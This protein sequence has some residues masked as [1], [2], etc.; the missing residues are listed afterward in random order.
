M[1]E[2]IATN[3]FKRLAEE[4][5]L[6]QRDIRVAKQILDSI[7]QILTEPQSINRWIFELLQNAADSCCSGRKL[8]ISID[9]TKE[10]LKFSHN[11]KAFVLEDL[12]NLIEQ[13]SSKERISPP[14]NA[15]N[16]QDLNGQEVKQIGKFG[17]GFL[18]TYILS[19]K[20]K[21]EG[22]FKHEIKDDDDDK[23]KAQQYRKFLLTMNRDAEKIEWMVKQIQHSSQ[24]FEYLDHLKMLQNYQEGVSLDTV[25]SYELHKTTVG[26]ASQ[27]L[28]ILRK[29]MPYLLL[30][31]NNI[32]SIIIDDQIQKRKEIFQLQQEKTDREYVFN[33]TTFK[34][35]K[36][37]FFINNQPTSKLLQIKDF[38]LIG[39]DALYGSLV[40]N[41]QYLQPNEKRTGL[42]LDES[43]KGKQNKEIFQEMVKLYSHL[44]DYSIKLDLKGFDNLLIKAQLNT[45]SNNQFKDSLLIP[46]IEICLSKQIIKSNSLKMEKLDD[47]FIPNIRNN[48][49]SNNPDEYQ[50]FQGFIEIFQM[51]DKFRDDQIIQTEY[52]YVKQWMGLNEQPDWKQRMSQSNQIGIEYIIDFIHNQGS[53]TNLQHHLNCN[54]GKS[55]LNL[56]YAYAAKYMDSKAFE[57]CLRSKAITPNILITK[58]SN[59]NQEKTA[60]QLNHNT[61]IRKP[62]KGVNFI[63]NDLVKI[64]QEFILGLIIV[65]IKS[66]DNVKSFRQY[67]KQQN[68]DQAIQDQDVYKF[69]NKFYK[70]ATDKHKLLT[71]R[72]IICPKL[73]PNQQGNFMKYWHNNKQKSI[74]QISFNIIDKDLS[75]VNFQNMEDLYDYFANLTQRGKDYLEQTVVNRIFNKALIKSENQYQIETYVRCQDIQ[76]LRV[77]DICQYLDSYIIRN[78]NDKIFIRQNEEFFNNF[79][80]LYASTFQDNQKEFYFSQYTKNRLEILVELRQTGEVTKAM[81]KI[82]CQKQ[83]QLLFKLVEI[84]PCINT[85]ALQVLQ[86][87]KKFEDQPKLFQSFFNELLSDYKGV[88]LDSNDID[89]L[90]EKCKEL[91]KKKWDKKNHKK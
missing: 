42:I 78:S 91:K 31:N 72:S 68:T 88:E 59:L 49:M 21:V 25:F 1:Q 58:S 64:C 9:L 74:A 69:L 75:I 2:D 12:I 87:L 73:I 23:I 35:H 71:Q 3:N 48:P 54:D 20:V 85:I 16:N 10:Y 53:I 67:L 77:K 45:L 62:I 79:E 84:D 33:K 47:I 41:S 51:M 26:N 66:C 28:D 18:T 8:K 6:Q 19:K 57:D 50:Q 14:T 43:L 65:K 56:V 80:N 39:F 55:F 40:F 76:Y 82:F 29:T 4:T 27:G 63:P 81:H 70:I 61:L 52:N 15:S 60:F 11:G 22:I 5:K 86:L 38:P 46:C 13:G 37:E 30:F 89:A 36:F 83:E 44:I 34:L 24:I 17:T 32:E 90:I 7:E